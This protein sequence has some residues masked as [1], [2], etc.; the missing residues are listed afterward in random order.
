MKKNHK[1]FQAKTQRIDKQ[2][3]H[4]DKQKTLS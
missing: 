2:V 1:Q 4:K 3:D